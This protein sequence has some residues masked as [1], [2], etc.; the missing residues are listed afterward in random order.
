MKTT[1]RLEQAIKKLYT[2]FH[3]DTLHPECCQ[4]CAVGNILDNTDTWKHLSDQHGSSQLNYVGIVHQKLG[5]TFN[6]YSPLELLTIEAT[7]LKACGYILPLQKHGKKPKNPQDKHLLFEGLCATVTYLCAL[8]GV[9]NVMD[10]SKIFVI[11]NNQ[12]R[13]QLHELI[14]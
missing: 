8:D 12:P 3:A 11:E 4:H 2:A 9:A 13:F 7:F 10:Y 14:A 6:G 5:R 1:Y